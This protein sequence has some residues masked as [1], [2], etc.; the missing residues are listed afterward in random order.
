M[1]YL[2]LHKDICFKVLK[3]R[4]TDQTLFFHEYPPNFIIPRSFAN[5]ISSIHC[6]HMPGLSKESAFVMIE[7][8][9]VELQMYFH[10]KV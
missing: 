6:H 8:E 2:A 7:T 10:Q 1:A 4:F 3:R 5:I 9:A